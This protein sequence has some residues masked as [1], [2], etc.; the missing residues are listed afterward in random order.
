MIPASAAYKAI[1]ALKSGAIPALRAVLTPFLWPNGVNVDGTFVECTYYAPDRVQADYHG[2]SGGYWISPALNSQLQVTSSPAT[3]TWGWNSPGFD[4]LLYWRFGNSLAALA[5]ASWVLLTQG[6]TIQIAPYYQFKLTLEGY[7]A[8]AEDSAGGADDFTA[9]A[10]DTAN[11]D[12]YQGYAAEEN[13][14]GDVLTYIEG[15]T[16]LGEF[17]IVSDIEQAGSVS[18][19]APKAFDDLVAGS[20]SGLVLNNRQEGPDTALKAQWNFL[21][22]LLDDTGKGHT[23]SWQ[24]GGSPS[25]TTGLLPGTTAV[26]LDGSHSLSL[27]DHVDF[28]PGTGPFSVEV[29]VE[30]SALTGEPVFAAKWLGAPSY[31]GWGLF[32]SGGFMI[33]QVIE[34]WAAVKYRTGYLQ[35]TFVAG[36]KYHIVATWDSGLDIQIY[37]NGQQQLASNEGLL[38]P[39]NLDCS[40]DLGIGY[41]AAYGIHLQGKIDLVRFIKGRALKSAEVSV[42]YEGFLQ[43]EIIPDTVPAPLYS[44]NKASFVMAGNNWFDTKL[45]VE[46]GWNEAGFTDFIPIFEGKISKWGPVSRGVGSPTNVEIYAKDWVMECLNKRIAL[47]KA[48][49]TPD[50]LTLGEFLAKGEAISGWAPGLPARTAYFEDGTF[51]E[52]DHLVK[53]GGADCSVIAPGLTGAHAFRCQ[54]SGANQTAYGSLVL[55][56]GE[57]FVTGRMRFQAAPGSPVN[58]NLTFLQIIDSTGSADFSLTLTNLGAIYGSLGGESKFNVLGYV[59]VPI[60]WALWLSP[61]NPGYARLWINGDEVLA[62]SANLSGQSPIEIRFG[63]QT[64]GTSETWVI[65]YD[66]IE[67]RGKYYDNA[68][69]VTGAPFVSIGPVYIDNVAQPDNKNVG[70]YVQTLT[71]LPQYGMVQFTSTDPAFKMSSGDVLIRVVE[72]PGGIHALAVIETLLAIAGLS[73]KVDATALTAA[74]AAVPNDFINVRFDGKGERGAGLKDIASL[75]VAVGDCLK[76]VCARCLYWFFVDAGAIKI[77]PYT[78]ITPGAP[79]DSLKR[80]SPGNLYEATQ[81]IDLDQLFAFV[82]ATYGWYERNDSLYYVAGVQEA[83]GQGAGLDFTWG[84]PVACERL[85]MVKAKADML[86]KFLSAQERLEPVRL[87]LAGARIELMETVSVQDEI[88]NEGPA[89][90]FVTRKDIGLDPGA[91]ETTLQLMKFLG[92]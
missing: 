59:D 89:Y 43:G 56:S 79:D 74:Y 75:G 29:I 26:I 20:H 91:R 62:Y 3:I 25:Y 6:G 57:L 37:V 88:L 81:T 78:G 44:P 47:P 1:E 12:A 52:L 61:T 34:D 4:S 48:D 84:S 90:Y 70:A 11:E 65:D 87:S 76:E 9:W 21:S 42:R 83:G 30:F 66:D 58:A 22:N 60:S 17:P 33:F 14:P 68:F 40:A 32:L 41:H 50:P 5:A 13:V 82:T 72:T 23:L 45:R 16:I 7:R 38:E 46:M 27:S 36:I 53:L 2:F 19:E 73:S 77:V 85:D 28:R 92:E 80:L 8:W 15:I 51:N 10:E 49:G 55:P 69:Q 54:T 63:A 24:G 64:A 86:L 67:V 71:R 31:Q 39:L 18:L 35:Y